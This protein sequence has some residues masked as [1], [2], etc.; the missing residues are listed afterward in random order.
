MVICYSYVKVYLWLTQLSKP[1]ESG[2]LSLGQVMRDLLKE[3]VSTSYCREVGFV[4]F[5][6]RTAVLEGVTEKKETM[7]MATWKGNKNHSAS[8]L[9]HWDLN[10]SDYAENE[11]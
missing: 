9:N 1:S 7:A 4:G 5:G 3:M 10:G 8:M 6:F 11:L 2:R